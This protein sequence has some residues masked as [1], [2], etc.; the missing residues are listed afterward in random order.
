MGRVVMERRETI[1]CRTDVSGQLKCV[2]KR[3]LLRHRPG[4]APEVIS[5]EEVEETFDDRPDFESGF[6]TDSIES[7]NDLLSGFVFQ[8]IGQLPRPVSRPAPFAYSTF[9][10]QHNSPNS[11]EPTSALGF[12]RRQRPSRTADTEGAASQAPSMR[13]SCVSTVYT[14]PSERLVR[15]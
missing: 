9:D 8:T 4:K 15:I 3:T 11:S 7:L 5:T 13:R 12:R 1:E 10:Q 6:E 2:R 14:D